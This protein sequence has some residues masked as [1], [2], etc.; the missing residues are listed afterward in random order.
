VTMWGHRES[1][2]PAR[3]KYL[4]LNVARRALLVWAGLALS[5][6]PPRAKAPDCNTIDNCKAVL[7]TL[8][9][10]H[11]CH[12]GQEC[13]MIPDGHA[14][15][16]KLRDLEA[17]RHQ[18]LATQADAVLSARAEQ[19]RAPR[20]N[21]SAITLSGD[22]LQ[23]QP[24]ITPPATD[25]EA[26]QKPE[27]D[28]GAPSLSQEEQFEQTL[29][30]EHAAIISELRAL[31][32]AA[33]EARLRACHADVRTDVNCAP[34]V[35]QLIEAAT[36][37]NEQWKLA[38]LRQ[39]LFDREVRLANGV[40]ARMPRHDLDVP[41]FVRCCDGTSY[42]TGWCTRQMCCVGLGGI[43]TFAPAKEWAP[44]VAV[45]QP[46]G[47]PRRDGAH[48]ASS[49]PTGDTPL[50]CNDGELSPTCTCGGNHRGCCSSH[51]GIR[52]CSR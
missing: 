15:F 23:P 34:L 1:A 13:S 18:R 27:I 16:F 52:G 2:E 7:E 19:L 40:M 46:K 25:P 42:Q 51:R 3:V 48:A 44:G 32:P 8:H 6:V 43:C 14:A 26:E 4:P 5:C 24:P 45:V 33:R 11:L 17:A 37:I 36:D 10:Q 22:D 29:E 30:R 9:L 12:S 49:A 50:V 31:S 21:N 47:E 38:G 28:G 20:E 39:Y 41:G 35:E